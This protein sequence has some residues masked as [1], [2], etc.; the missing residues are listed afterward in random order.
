MNKLLL[1]D[2][3]NIAQVPNITYLVKDSKGFLILRESNKAQLKKV[4]G[5]IGSN[6]EHIEG[7]KMTPYYKLN[8]LEHEWQSILKEVGE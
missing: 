8:L 7:R 6:L 5:W 3:E 1:T 4:V 2:E